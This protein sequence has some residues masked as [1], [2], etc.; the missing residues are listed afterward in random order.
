[1][2]E[3]HEQDLGGWARGRRVWAG[4]GVPGGARAYT[5]VPTPGPPAKA[6]GGGLPRSPPWRAGL[7]SGRHIPW[8]SRCP[9]TWQAAPPGHRAGMWQ[10]QD[11]NP[12]QPNSRAKA[13]GEF[14]S[15][16]GCSSPASQESPC[17]QARA[18]IFPVSSGRVIIHLLFALLCFPGREMCPEGEKFGVN[19]LFPG[20]PNPGSATRCLAPVSLAA[21]LPFPAVWRAAE[22]SLE[23]PGAAGVCVCAS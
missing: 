1:M 18:H 4:F 3:R 20:S 14:Q 9:E 15:V 16:Q 13:S 17:P 21:L 11:S 8:S 10:K 7:D 2:P 23:K 22:M 5:Q 19:F 12:P 6:L